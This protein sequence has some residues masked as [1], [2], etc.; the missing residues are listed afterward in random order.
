MSNFESSAKSE[1]PVS[2]P[3]AGIKVLDLSQFILGPISTQ[4][5]GDM[6]AQ[7]I[8]VE[9]PSGDMNRD[10]GPQRHEKMSALF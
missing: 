3:L 8:K 4:I 2:G 1:N 7:V 9:S 5:M 10:I 6:G